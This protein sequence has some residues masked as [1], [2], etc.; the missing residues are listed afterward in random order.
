MDGAGAARS[1]VDRDYIARDNP[2][3]ARRTVRIIL[4]SVETLT[5]FPQAGRPGRVRNTRE[6]VIAKTPF[7]APYR[8]RD[9]R[10]E[11]LAVFH[12]ARLWPD[13]L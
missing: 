13:K 11:I 3:A 8:V 1:R 4:G 12:G 2:S 10:I 7:I 9:D 6:L 5:R